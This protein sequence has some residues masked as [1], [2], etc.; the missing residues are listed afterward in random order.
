MNAF[1]ELYHRLYGRAPSPPRA[2]KSTGFV[3]L[4][5]T[6]KIEEEHM[7]AYAKRLF[8]PAKL[9]DVIRERYQLLC[10]LGYGANSAV[11]LCRDLK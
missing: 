6:T 10:K 7:P 2:V 11:W 1:R 8:Y 4:D 3:S 5:P 9:G